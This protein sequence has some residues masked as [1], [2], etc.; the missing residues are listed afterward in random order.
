[1][2][3]VDSVLGKLEAD[4]AR[5]RD[6]SGQN[7]EQLDQAGWR[8]TLRLYSVHAARA[9]MAPIALSCTRFRPAGSCIG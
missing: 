6:P 5:T 4:A 2:A 3:D 8:S 1:M 7:F 9:R